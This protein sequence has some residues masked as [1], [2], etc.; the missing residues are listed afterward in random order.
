MM[1]ALILAAALALASPSPSPAPVNLPL[2]RHDCA[3]IIAV[4]HLP[5]TAVINAETLG[6]LFTASVRL[7]GVYDSRPVTLGDLVQGFADVVG[8]FIHPPTK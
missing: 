7:N 3:A 8:C 6:A 4:A 2:P 5:A 1:L